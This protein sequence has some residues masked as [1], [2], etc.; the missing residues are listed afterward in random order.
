[1]ARFANPALMHRTRQIAMDGSQ[2]LP[3]RLLATLAAR[4][5][6]R[7]PALSL[8][9]AAWMRWQAG[10]DDAGAAHTVDDPL[11]ARTATALDG[12]RSEE[13]TSELQSLMRSSYAVFC[14]KKKTTSLHFT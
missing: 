2:K 14:L 11:A 9:V 8:A 10:V 12:T 4:R 7:S 13:H 3:Q 5:G 1:M 6:Q